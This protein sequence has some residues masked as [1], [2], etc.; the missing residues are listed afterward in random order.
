[1]AKAGDGKPRSD[2]RRATHRLSKRVTDEEF[3][4]FQ[5]R[6]TEAGFALCQDFLSAFISGDTR[7]HAATRKDTIR[8][9]GEL[10]K[11]GSNVNQIARA[12]N[13]GRAN[14]LDPEAMQTLE[15]TR[16]LIEALGE[17]IREAL[18]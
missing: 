9:L 11:L 13:Q 14:S 5:K 12:L 6:A 1:M 15:E 3:S 17:E 10:G 8:L 2:M 16:S 18:L 7:L 4:M